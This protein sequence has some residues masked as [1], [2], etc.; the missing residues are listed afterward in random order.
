MACIWL[1]NNGI[2]VVIELLSWNES[3][4]LS[5]CCCLSPQFEE[6]NREEDEHM[7]LHVAH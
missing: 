6:V 1:G 3:V 7:W 5:H 4:Y 2:G